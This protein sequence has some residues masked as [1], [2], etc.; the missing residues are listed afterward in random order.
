MRY[1][2]ILPALALAYM[3]SAGSA[4]A[5]DWAGFYVGIN[6][7]S[8]ELDANWTTTAT[9][10]PD[11]ENIGVDSDAKESLGGDESA[12]GLRIGY[13]WN[14]DQWVVG[15]EAITGSSEYTSSIDRIPGLDIAGNE[16]FV[17]INAESGG[18]SLRVRG[19]YLV[20][21]ELLLYTT[22]G[23]VELDVDVTTTCP[24]D[25]DV[26]N[27]DDG[28]QSFDRSTSLSEMDIGFGVEYAINRFL[29]HL[30]I[31]DVDLG[32]FRFT[33]IPD[34]DNSSFGADAR[35]SAKID[36]M[37]FGVSYKF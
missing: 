6:Q 37:Q 28:T 27:S 22:V 35:I 21:P 1:S 15:V 10:D 32:D 33:A 25:D 31:F 20:M 4:M 29:I 26:C 30:E 16:S 12:T 14:F 17:D 36:T 2:R 23:K 7:A 5:A 18:T 19:G 11:G 34:Q 3:F 8:Q 9:R 24:V 13:N